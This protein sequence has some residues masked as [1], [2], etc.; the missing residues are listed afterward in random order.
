[1]SNVIHNNLPEFLSSRGF[2]SADPYRWAHNF[3]QYTDGGPWVTFLVLDPN[4]ETVTVTFRVTQDS[5]GLRLFT[6][7][8]LP[9]DVR[10][11]FDFTEEGLPIDPHAPYM[12]NLTSYLKAVREMDYAALTSL[13]RI[14]RGLEFTIRVS[15]PTPEEFDATDETPFPLEHCVGLLIGAIVEGSPATYGPEQFLFP[16]SDTTFEATLQALSDFTTEAW[17]EA[18]L[19][20]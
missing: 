9:L 10:D 19:E 18:E 1:M 15:E 16:F 3:S 6:G 11:A 8:T 14:R 12:A 5:T 2:P 17:N 7:D 20:T 13:K 4:E